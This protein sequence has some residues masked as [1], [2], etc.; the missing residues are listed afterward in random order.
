MHGLSELS[1]FRVLRDGG[2]RMEFV[3]ELLRACAYRAVP[4][5]VRKQLHSEV[6]DWLLAGKKGGEQAGGLE[7]A[8]HCIRAGRKEQAI[9]YLLSGA[10]EALQLGAPHETELSL[11]TALPSLPPT[12]AI[13]ARLLIVEAIQEQGRWDESLET[14][15]PLITLTSEKDRVAVLTAAAAVQQ[16]SMS[17]SERN[18]TR[19]RMLL[20]ARRSVDA[21]TRLRAAQIAAQTL[22]ELRDPSAAREVLLHIEQLPTA[23]LNRQEQI[24][25]GIARAQALFFQGERI[26]SMAEVNR[27]LTAAQQ[28]PPLVNSTTLHLSVAAATMLVGLGSYEEATTQYTHCFELSTRLGRQSGAASA[29]ANL[30]LCH[31][32]LGNTSEQLK[33]AEESL[34]LSERFG[35]YVGR[36]HAMYC[37]AAAFAFREENRIV[38]TSIYETDAWLNDGMPTWVSQC[39]LLYKADLLAL[40][41]AR[42]DAVAAAR[43]AI[44]YDRLGPLADYFT[45]A[46]ARWCAIAASTLREREAT[47]DYL[48]QLHSAGIVRDALDHVEIMAGLCF[49]DGA[50]KHPSL[51]QELAGRLF[52]LPQGISRL[53]KALRVVY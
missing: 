19:K 1:K 52:Q 9:P 37:R 4:S 45:G 13:E 23:S 35:S 17:A 48:E 2:Q 3:N 51:P 5:P 31:F 12:A 33:W 20:I 26:A 36:L 28:L 44:H 11:G 42:T 10:R 46:Y 14:L 50:R 18:D 6:A 15:Q 38:K 25:W 39:W 27:L 24:D 16:W 21:L 29:A 30:S 47:M 34:A 8:W 43:K 40:V 32:R 49:L 41:G 7:I 53:L 22:N